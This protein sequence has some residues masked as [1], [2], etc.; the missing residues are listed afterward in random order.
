MNQSFNTEIAK[1]LDVPCAIFIESLALWIK[2]N[3][4]HNEHFYDGYYWT[5]ISENDLTKIFPYW[6]RRQIQTITLKLQ[7]NNIIKTNNYNDCKLDRT[8]WYTISN[9]NIAKYYDIRG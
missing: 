8:K 7:N 4:I 3:K 6:T 1:M 9:Q 2:G 5:C